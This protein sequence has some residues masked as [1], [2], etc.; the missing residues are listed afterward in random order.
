M[1]ELLCLE[2]NPPLFLT[3]KY[4]VPFGLIIMTYKELNAYRNTL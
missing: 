2:K 3:E 4:T 1:T